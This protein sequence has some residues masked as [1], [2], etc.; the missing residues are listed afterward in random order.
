MRSAHLTQLQALLNT[1]VTKYVAAVLYR[2]YSSEHVYWTY[3]SD[4]IE[5]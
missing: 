1:I 2:V 4:L 3:V 5:L